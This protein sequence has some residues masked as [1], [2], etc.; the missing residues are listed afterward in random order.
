MK[1]FEPLNTS[2]RNFP[3]ERDL[4]IL[5]C[6]HVPYAEQFWVEDSD[7]LGHFGA[8][9]KNAWMPLGGPVNE[10]VI[11]SMAQ[12]LIGYAVLYKS[13]YFDAELAG[14]S[15]DHLLDRL[16]RCLRWIAGHH[17]SGDLHTAP[18]EWN[19]QWG[20][21][22]ESSLWAGQFGVAA[23]QVWDELDGDVRE[24]ALKVLAFE[25]D[26]FVGVDVPDGRWLDTKAEENAWDA[27]LMA[28]AYCLQP[29]HPHAEIWLDRS[30]AFAMNTFSTDRDRVEKGLIDGRPIGDW[31]CTQTAHPDLTVENHGSF[32]PSYLACGDLLLAGRLA[33]LKTGK[34]PPPH[35]M[36]HVREVWDILKRFYL[37]NGFMVYPS[38][39]DWKYQ[40]PESFIQA[41]VMAGE[42]G[43][44]VAGHLLCEVMRYIDEGML[45]AGDGRFDGRI[46]PAPGG[47]YFQFETGMM[48]D[49]AIAIMAGLPETFRFQSE[50]YRHKL[51]GC[52]AYP[53]VELQVRRSRAGFFSFSWRS[54]GARVMGTVIPSG[55]EDTF[56]ADQDGLVGRF[57]LDG[58]RVRP[59]VVCH[60][61]RTTEKG[62]CTTGRML[63][64]D[65]AIDQR[66]AVVALEDGE[67]VVF[68]DVTE[69]TDVSRVTLNEGLGVYVMNDFPNKNQV[70]LMYAGGKKLVRGVGGK[71]RVIETHS[72]WL[73]VAG[74]LGIVTDGIT[75]Y[76]DDASERNTPVRWKSVLQDRVFVKPTANGTVIRDYCV[77]LRLGRGGTRRVKAAPERL[78]AQDGVRVFRLS[79]AKNKN[80][81]V[82]VNV[83]VKTRSVDIPGLGPIDL[84]AMDVKIVQSA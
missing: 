48:W 16:N 52:E 70:S 45:A 14:V 55:G 39:Q 15:R 13:P 4:V 67:T 50:M 81:I 64:G 23:W 1:T 7:A 54:L 10:I 75:L 61:D 12:E 65:G 29:D 53:Y 19:G 25:A 78:I 44:E 77:L 79:D 27:F 57:E 35:F 46:P 38:G 30:K 40:W 74:S 84:P 9:D 33:F 76:Y 22:W 20:D 6:R 62:F 11:R 36:Y 63:Y 31:I 58:E 83:D 68:V 18:L 3:S 59:N 28:W 56:G 66:V 21:D 17:L 37:C 34:E 32:H 60:T 5:M 73:C 43:D 82:A 69:A 26:R 24:G 2:F 49:L 71:T 72:H 51:L 8:L 41:A 47:R 80:V 42:F